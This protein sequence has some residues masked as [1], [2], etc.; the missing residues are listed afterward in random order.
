MW[1]GAEKQLRPAK[2]QATRVYVSAPSKHVITGIYNS[3]ESI[4]VHL[5]VVIASPEEYRHSLDARPAC[6]M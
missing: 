5:S 1:N 3:N 4:N 2:L 6:M